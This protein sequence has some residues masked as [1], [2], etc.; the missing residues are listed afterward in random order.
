MSKGLGRMGM[1]RHRTSGHAGY[2]P[3]FRL[4]RELDLRKNEQKK[5]KRLLQYSSI[6]EALKREG[7]S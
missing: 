6:K 2:S 4:N 5:L 7:T 1:S 3:K